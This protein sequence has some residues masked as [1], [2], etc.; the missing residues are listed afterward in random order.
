MVEMT[1]E[2]IVNALKLIEAS[3]QEKTLPHETEQIK[4]M[5]AKLYVSHTNREITLSD[6][7][8]QMIIDFLQE[9]S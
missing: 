3:L 1:S 9:T 7:D 8:F 6:D 2:R 4:I 5:A